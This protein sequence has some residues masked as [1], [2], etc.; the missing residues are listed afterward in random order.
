MAE[1]IKKVIDI[2]V[3]G[4][5]TVRSLTTSI[6]ELTEALSKCNAESEQFKT[7]FGELSVSQAKLSKAM[8]AGKKDT[9]SA[10]GSYNALK[11]EMANLR[12]E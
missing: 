1:E 9:E 12:K 3:K 6:K 7:I 8:N 2:N 5:D 10:A 4:A 11:K